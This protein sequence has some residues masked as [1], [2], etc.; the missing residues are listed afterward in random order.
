MGMDT[1]LV[2]GKFGHGY[3][4]HFVKPTDWQYHN[5]IAKG[6]APFDWSKPY[7]VED[8]IGFLLPDKDQG[9]SGS[10][11]LQMASFYDQ[12]LRRSGEKSAHYG[13]QQIYQP[14]G[15]TFA[16]DIG[17]LLKSQ[18]LSQEKLCPSYNNGIVPDE[19]YMTRHDITP[20]MK[21]DAATAEITNY[22]FILQFNIDTLAQAIRDNYG[23][24]GALMGQNNGTWLTSFPK[25][26]T[27]PEWGHFVYFGRAK[28]INGKKY[29][30]FKN[31]WGPT[32]GDKGWQYISEDYVNSG[33]FVLGMVM[34]LG[35]K[36]YTFLKDLALGMTDADVLFLQ[37][38]LN[39]NPATMIAATGPGSP[40]N[41]TYYFG[42][43][44]QNAVALY[45]RAHGI[46][47]TGYFGPLTRASVNSQ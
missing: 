44:T 47:P 36:T 31:S 3:L 14:G 16:G 30:G 33:Y 25:P 9:T 26:P 39:Q 40:G 8:D 2:E 5:F 35:P 12:A 28:M 13:Y 7:S 15:G 41:E 24:G 45:Q 42:N 37:K 19:V 4:G 22:S 6:T 17:Y 23:I 20:L 43:L 34:M 21:A 1:T 29:L 46:S 18:G 32:V 11:G 38:K 27:N 10:C